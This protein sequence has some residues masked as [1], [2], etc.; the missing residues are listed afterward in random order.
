[1]IEPD[2]SLKFGVIPALP[3]SINSPSQNSEEAKIV[4]IFLFFHPSYLRLID[5]VPQLLSLNC[6]FFSISTSP[7]QS[8]IISRLDYFTNHLIL[9]CSIQGHLIPNAI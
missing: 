3:T 5:S 9:H 4:P 7:V 1:M 8:L 6:P 2:V